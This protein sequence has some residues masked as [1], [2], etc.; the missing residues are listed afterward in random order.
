MKK[1]FNHATFQSLW[2]SDLSFAEMHLS[3]RRP[4]G[5]LILLQ[6][7]I[8]SLTILHSGLEILLLY[9]KKVLWIFYIAG[10]T[11]LGNKMD[12]L[13]LATLFAP[14]LMH[15]FNDDPTKGSQMTS[16]SERMD[17]VSA[18]KLLIERRDLVFQV[19]SVEL[20]DAYVY[21]NEHFPD[22]LDALLRRRSALAGI[23]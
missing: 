3:F 21:L 15:S 23:E 14:N 20:N 10:N 4:S 12:S 16:A 5:S 18:L 13:N 2:Q 8:N 22:V 11:V 6:H 7:I 1:I 19:P 17:H 9:E